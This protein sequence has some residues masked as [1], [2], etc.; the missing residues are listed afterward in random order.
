MPF[1]LYILSQGQTLLLFYGC[2][3]FFFF[4]LSLSHTHTFLHNLFI[5]PEENSFTSR[6]H[7]W[8]P[9]FALNIFP[10]VRTSW[11][12]SQRDKVAAVLSDPLVTHYRHLKRGD[13]VVNSNFLQKVS[14]WFAIAAHKSRI[15]YFWRGKKKRKR[16]GAV[17]SL[18]PSLRLGYCLYGD[19]VHVLHVG[20]L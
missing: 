16:G 2:L 11:F 17:V 6:D 9:L 10:K 7:L 14:K 12:I 4:F 8:K 5:P 15:H 1:R 20:F 3:V 13:S 18:A 19:S